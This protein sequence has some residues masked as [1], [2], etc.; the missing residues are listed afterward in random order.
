[1]DK[2]FFTL[3]NILNKEKKGPINH[4]SRLKSSQK[5]IIS[6]ILPDFAINLLESEH[7]TQLI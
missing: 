4:K 5:K 6:N 7:R 3:K 1:M 2:A